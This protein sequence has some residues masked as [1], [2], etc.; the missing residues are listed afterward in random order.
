V[1]LAAFTLLGPLATGWAKRAG[2]PSNLLAKA[3]PAA[4]VVRTSTPVVGSRSSS[5]PVPGPFTATLSGSVVQKTV[6][7]GALVDLNLHLA[8]GA[9]GRLRIRLAGAPIPG[10]G[11]SMTGSQVDLL[12][13]G[14]HSVLTGQIS[15]LEGQN[16]VARVVG[17]GGALTLSVRLNIDQQNG[18]VSGSVHA[19]TGTP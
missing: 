2:T 8:G 15:S 16:F 3:P 14:L 4:T 5:G 19:A 7:G 13:T 17:S 12:K 11:L 1:G 18:R 6:T 9:Q 10:G